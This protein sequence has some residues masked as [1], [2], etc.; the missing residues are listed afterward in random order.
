M[1][2]VTISTRIPKVT[3]YTVVR[4]IQ[5]ASITASSSTQFPTYYFSLSNANVGSGFFDQYRIPAV[6]FCIRAQQNAIGL[7][8]NANTTVTSLYCVID[9]D[10]DTALASIAAAQS[11]SSCLVLPPG[12]SCS[13]TFRPHLALA[14][15]QGA[16]TGYVNESNQWI[17][18]ASNDVRHY[19][20]KLVVPGVTAAQT[21]LQS[22]DVSIEYFI[23]LR[24]AI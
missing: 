12:Q 7:T 1:D 6:R 15:Y 8:T 13:R 19:G 16:F 17:D 3:E 5:N 2:V 24:K 9:Y 11:Y 10:D 4:G 20:V 23:E 14:A 21:Q 22:W 18:S